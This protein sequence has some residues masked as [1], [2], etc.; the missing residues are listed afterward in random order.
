VS[1]TLVISLDFELMWGVRDHRSTADYGDA[2]LG[3]RQALPAL[4]RLFQTHGIQATWATVGLLFARDRREMLAHCPALEPGYRHRDLSPYDAIRSGIGASEADDPWHY[5]RSLVDQVMAVE[6]QELATH[7]FSHFYCMEEGPGMAAF[8]ADLQAATGIMAGAG[9]RPRSIVFP[10]NQMTDAHVQA[11]ARQGILSFR[12]NPHSYAYR[13]RSGDDNGPL[14]R[15]LRLLDASFPLT[16]SHAYRRPEQVGGCVDVRAS[17]FFRPYS[18][19]MG[20]LNDLHVRRIVHEMTQAA[21]TGEVYHLWWHPHNF[22]RHTERQLARLGTILLA[23]RRLAD[24]HGMR[25]QT[26]AGCAAAA[27]STT[28]PEPSAT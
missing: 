25:S 3:V 4:L 12:G 11:C 20:A 18:P 27:A 22:G 14:V 7:T 26:M 1:G 10:R 16:G 9:V 24:T 8:E 23:F 21:R 28:T 5:G 17:R 15:G 6:G 2:V 13:A 19:R